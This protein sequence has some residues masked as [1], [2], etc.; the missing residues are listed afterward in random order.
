MKQ[1]LLLLLAWPLVTFAADTCVAIRLKQERAPQ[2]V[3][4]IWGETSKFW[5]PKTVLPVQ[6]LDGSSG[7]RAAAWKRFQQID[8]L[9]SIQFVQT[10][11]KGIIRVSF[12]RNAGHWSYV[13][14]DNLNI[15][16]G[17]T[18]NLALSSGIF[19]DG[20]SEWD[21]I[22]LHECLHACGLSHEHQHPQAGIPWNKPAVYAYYQRTQGWSK[23]QIDFQ[24]LNRFKGSEWNG[25]SFD[26]TSIMEYPVP[27]ELTAN[28]FEVG[29]NAKLS[30]MDIQFIQKLYPLA[31]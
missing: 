1:I 26:P 28:G 12:N 6:F 18:M 9:V 31:K 5:G 13:G 7:Q 16:S 30:P 10:T 11:G 15:A 19:G 27:K 2:G 23:S 20:D 21:R 14:R 17:P 4:R 22:T 8:A 3:S 29:W 25:T 24:V